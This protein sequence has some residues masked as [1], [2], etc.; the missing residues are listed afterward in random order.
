MPTLGLDVYGQASSSISVE[1]EAGAAQL[2]HS[3]STKRPHA[4]LG[5][6]ESPAS[7]PAKRQGVAELPMRSGNAGNT[8]QQVRTWPW[9]RGILRA[10]HS[11]AS[12]RRLFP[13]P[14]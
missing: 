11:N 12:P 1:P 14:H 9:A 13:S 2:F 10:S 6:A 8:S 7:V 3:L 4:A 5:P